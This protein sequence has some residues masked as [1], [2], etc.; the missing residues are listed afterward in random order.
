[1]KE[2]RKKDCQDSNQATLNIDIDTLRECLKQDSSLPP[3]SDF[4][5]LFVLFP[6]HSLFFFFF[7]VAISGFNHSGRIVTWFNKIRALCQ[8]QKNKTSLEGNLQEAFWK[9]FQSSLPWTCSLINWRN[10]MK[11]RSSFRF[12]LREKRVQ[13]FLD[14]PWNFP[15]RW[16]IFRGF[17]GKDQEKFQEKI[18]KV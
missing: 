18:L 14:L 2:G 16:R 7:A 12:N 3:Q 4:D 13:S 6:I 15:L 9:A 11:K 5:W 10:S 17:K 1:M 8:K